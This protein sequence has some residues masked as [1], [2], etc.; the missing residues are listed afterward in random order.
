MVCIKARVVV[1]CVYLMLTGRVKAED[2]LGDVVIIILQQI[3]DTDLFI[4][5]CCVL[6]S[7]K[8]GLLL[9]PFNQDLSAYTIS[10]LHFF[11]CLMQKH[12]REVMPVSDRKVLWR[13]RVS[14]LFFLRQ[15]RRGRSSCFLAVVTRKACSSFTLSHRGGICLSTVFRLY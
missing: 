5:V 9:L 3:L 13:R 6:L 12:R 8:L 11:L 7:L 14:G 2:V 1:L 15:T 4:K 10:F